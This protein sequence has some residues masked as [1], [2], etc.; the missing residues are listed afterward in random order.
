MRVKRFFLY[1]PITAKLGAWRLMIGTTFNA[2]CLMIRLMLEACRLTL[3]LLAACRLLL[4]ASR[5]AALPSRAF[6]ILRKILDV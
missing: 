3:L 4:D 1:D 2:C 6:D 5:Y